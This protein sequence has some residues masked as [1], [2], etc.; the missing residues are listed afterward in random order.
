MLKSSRSS[1]LLRLLARGLVCSLTL[2]TLLV[3]LPAQTSPEPKLQIEVL[4]GEGA[5]NNIRDRRAKEP[6]VRVVDENSRPVKGA[7]VS[8]ML[9]ELGASGLFPDTGTNLTAQ[10]D[11]MGQ[12]AGRG[13]K[14]N[15]IAGQFQIRVTASYRGQTASA[16]ISQTNAAPAAVK[17][18][19]SKKIAILLIV[20]GG[21]A[22]GALAAIQGGK[23]STQPSSPT[24]SPTPATTITPG[25][26]A[27]GPPR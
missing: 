15:N 7:T 10:T 6:V 22:G 26:G 20:A 18:G 1:G 23:G 17:R 13:L 2:E 25:N 4:E 3:P 19:S 21:A 24:P 8:F 14:P 12:A 11:E 5:I 27:F 9:P 16:I